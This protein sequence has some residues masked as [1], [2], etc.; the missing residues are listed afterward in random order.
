MKKDSTEIVID[1]SSP[2]FLV[3]NKFNEAFRFLKLEYLTRYNKPGTES[4]LYK[5]TN[6][7]GK[8]VNQLRSS[9]SK[10][11]LRITPYMTI[12]EVKDGFK[13]MFEMDVRI[14]RKSGNSWLAT[15]LTEGWTLEQQNNLGEKLSEGE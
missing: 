4:P 1:E 10:G 2:L 9:S 5:P 6:V 11:T 15:T 14:L 13:N 3:Q 7:D 8:T 12:A